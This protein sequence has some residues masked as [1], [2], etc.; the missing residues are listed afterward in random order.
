MSREENTPLLSPGNAQNNG[1]DPR[2]LVRQPI[3]AADEH[4]MELLKSAADAIDHGI[5]PERIYQGSSGSYFVKNSDHKTVAV[6]KPKDE[7][8]YGHLN[9]KWTKWMHKLCCPC[10]FGRSCLVPNQG[11]LSEAGASIVDEYLDL[12]IVPKTKVVRLVSETFNYTAVDKAKSRT[13]QT[14]AMHFPEIGR[15]FHRL[16]LPPKA[17]SFQ[18]FMD[19]CRDAENWL[20]VFQ[21]DPLS[22]E[23][24]TE[25]SFQ[26]EKLVCLDYIIRNTDRGN[27]NWLIKFIKDV[28]VDPEEPS[29]TQPK[30]EVVAIDNGL[31]FPYKHPDEWRAY[32]FH[33]AWLPMAKQPF[34]IRIK[35]HMLPKLNDSRF[36]SSL[37]R[38]LYKLFKTDPGFDRST[39]D[40]QMGVM[41]GQILNLVHSLNASES[42][43]QLVQKPVVTVEKTTRRHRNN[44]R[45]ARRRGRHTGTHGAT[46]FM[47]TANNQYSRLQNEEADQPSNLSAP[48]ALEHATSSETEPA[49]QNFFSL[50]SDEEDYSDD[51]ESDFYTRYYKRPFFSWF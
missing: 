39:F 28:E 38:Q 44:R 48:A 27:D 47:I 24:Q 51:T 31:A 36:V 13:K 10:C 19:G 30:I 29:S 45:R 17:G 9:P 11:Y 12:N 46:T 3:S 8:P 32:P 1:F 43:V 26:F 49:N 2:E 16:G 18:L 20:R 25:F 40:K 41:R 37:I 33:W 15:H 42:P 21:S 14:V 22:D 5:Y 4:F 23:T 34:S 50:I 35:E 7:E 6:F